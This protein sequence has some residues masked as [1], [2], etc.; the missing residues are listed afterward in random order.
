V[1]VRATRASDGDV[2]FVA[3]RC[4]PRDGRL[5]TGPEAIA[6]VQAQ[7]LATYRRLMP[8]YEFSDWSARP[9][10]AMTSAS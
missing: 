6:A 10:M 3:Q 9:D 8:G 7:Q 2:K 4:W 5:L 1:T